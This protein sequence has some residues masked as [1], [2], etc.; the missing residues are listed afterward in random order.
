MSEIW[1]SQKPVIVP[2]VVLRQDT[3]QPLTLLFDFLHRQIDRFT[4]N[5]KL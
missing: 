2:T 1:G 3:G 5:I 4:Q